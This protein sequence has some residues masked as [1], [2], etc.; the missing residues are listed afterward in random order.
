MKKIAQ[1]YLDTVVKVT[2]EY[3]WFM[4]INHQVMADT[5]QLS[6]ALDLEIPDQPLGINWEEA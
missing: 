2:P 6:I 1:E 3:A 4:D 5:G